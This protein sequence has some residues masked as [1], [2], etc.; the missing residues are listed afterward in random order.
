VPSPTDYLF[1]ID[2]TDTQHGW[3]SGYNYLP[4]FHGIILVT[5][6]GGAE[7]NYDYE[8]SASENIRDIDMSDS[9]NGTAVCTNGTI[10]RKSA[11]APDWDT[12]SVPGIASLNSLMYQDSIHVWAAGDDGDVIY[13]TDGGDSWVVDTVFTGYTIHDVYVRGDYRYVAMSNGEIFFTDSAP[14]PVIGKPGYPAAPATFAL[15]KPYPNP[16]NPVTIIRF[17]QPV[18]SQVNLSVFDISGRQVAEL[19]NGWRDAGVHEV[20]FDASDLASGVYLC[21]LQ[22]GSFSA[23]QKMVLMK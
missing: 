11:S 3:A 19:V 13:S 4:S 20:E 5:S 23:T 6:N 1:G 7:W 9:E 8:G 17:T 10:L 16:F 2:F 15:A 14:T 18:R 21:R 12:L 22:A